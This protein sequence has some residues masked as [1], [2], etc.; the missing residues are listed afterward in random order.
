MPFFNCTSPNAEKVLEGT[1]GT[2]LPE[3]LSIPFTKLP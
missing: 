3:K 1:E 2:V